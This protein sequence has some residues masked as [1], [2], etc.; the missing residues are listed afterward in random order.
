MKPQ[1]QSFSGVRP[2]FGRASLKSGFSLVEVLVAILVLG[3]ALV[4]L[5]Q[6]ITLA[7]TSTKESEWQSTA[8]LLAAGRIETLRAENDWSDGETQGDFGENLPQYRWQQTITGTRI[9][10]L[11]EVSVSVENARTG[12]PIYELRTLLFQAPEDSTAPQSSRS[13]RRSSR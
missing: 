10:G 12:Q 2:G 5:T 3:I 4:G 1:R 7:L 8:A 9:Q 11:H 6:G 13:E